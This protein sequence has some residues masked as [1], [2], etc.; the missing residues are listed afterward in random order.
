MTRSPTSLW[1]TQQLRNTT[2]F[3][4]GP[5][6]IIRDNDDKFG[7]DVDRVAKTCGISVL[8]TPV[9]APKANATW[10]RYLGSVRRKC[11][12]HVTI[13]GNKHAL[14][15]LREHVAHF[16]SGRPHQGIDQ[17]VPTGL[18]APQKAHLNMD[19]VGLPI[20]SGLQPVGSMTRGRAK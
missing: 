15:V 1:T 5:R 6:F 14:R 17:R 12:D 20:L 3:G 13:L 7:G 10:E 11:L 4:T 19:V 8:R 9:R 18:A 2:P 16:N